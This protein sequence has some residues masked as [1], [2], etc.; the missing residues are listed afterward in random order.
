[1]LK[2]YPGAPDLK[3][4]M[5][6]LPFR[7]ME[8]ADRFADGLIKAG[9]PGK[10][11]EYYKVYKEH[12]LSAEEIKKTFLGRSLT[13]FADQG[14]SMAFN[15]DENQRFVTEIHIIMAS[16]GLITICFVSG[17]RMLWEVSKTADICIVIPKVRTRRKMSISR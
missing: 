12:Q 2:K 9:L 5:N 4:V 6:F 3:S 1:M 8:I 14:W 15:K 16:G 17:G 7:D 10:P 13:G 11:S